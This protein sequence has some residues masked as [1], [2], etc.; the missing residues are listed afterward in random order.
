MAQEPGEDARPVGKLAWSQCKAVRHL[1]MKFRL[2]HMHGY[3]AAII[4]LIFLVLF[5]I[6]VR[7]HP[8]ADARQHPLPANSTELD[9]ELAH[10]KSDDPRIHA[11]TYPMFQDVHVMIFVG[12]GFLMTFL[13]KYG[14]SAV[15]LNFMISGLCLQWAILIHGFFH[16]HYGK[17]LL[18]LN[19]L[20][21]AD[22]STATVLITFGAV[23]GKTTPTQL[24]LMA[25]LEIPLFIIN[26]VIGRQYLGA[27]DMGD[28]MFVHTFGAYFGLGLSLMLYRR[29]NSTEKEGS[30][31]QSDIFAMIGTLFL[32]LYWP[33][34]NAGAAVGDDQHRAII[35]TYV[36]LIACC[37]T[38]FALSSILHKEKKF[39][40]V[41]IQNSTLAGGVAVGTSADMMIE[42]WGALL[43]GM[44]AGTL[45]VVGYMYLTPFL[46]S[47]LRIHDTC[48]V[49][50]LHGMPGILAGIIGCIVAAMASEATY[51][52]SL[53]EIFPA[54]APPAGTPELDQLRA[55]LPDL[56]GGSG[57]SA[58]AQAT[59]QILAL[60]ITMVISLA[61]G[62]ASGL[63]LRLKPFASLKTDELYEDEKYWLLEE[64]E[65][66]EDA[67]KATVNI[68][69]H[70]GADN[71]TTNVDASLGPLLA[72]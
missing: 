34:F 53:Y 51:G 62:I 50:N 23:L 9:N 24:L 28:S 41:H 61:G 55:Y 7:Y 36:S 27:V 40:M 68:P 26:E 2:S 21:G 38:A 29:D 14:F 1:I 60:I 69:M 5:C 11:K 15:G 30:S 54:R 4:Q 43:I 66:E 16:L 45:S 64:G 35:N 20:L 32:W 44:I 52:P 13:K 37:L 3:L 59:N 17:I 49:N 70:S 22:F 18:D 8:D 48:G 58:A 39:D 33:S 6:F 19:A 57:I 46:A 10:D 72:S 12:F 67:H 71:G 25:M 31:Y 63:I 47:R 56:E 42:P 65:E